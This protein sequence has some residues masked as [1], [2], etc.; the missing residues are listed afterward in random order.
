M[1]VQSTHKSYDAFYAKWERCR[2]VAEGSDAVHKAGKK[3]LP[4]LKDQND[5]DYAVY[6]QRAVFTNYTWRTIAVGVGMLFAKPAKIEV[7]ETI[8]PLLDDVDGEGTPMQLFVED[9][10]ENA[11]TVGRV[12]IMVDYPSAPPGATQADAKTLNLRPTMSIYRTES[13][14]NWRVASVNNRKVAVEVRLREFSEIVVDEFTTKEE[15]RLRVL[16]LIDTPTGK[17]YRQRLY[18]KKDTTVSSVEEY[19]QIGDDLFPLMH[20]ATMGYIPFYICST[21]DTTW[22]VDDPPLIDLVDL[23]LA[24][25]RNSAIYEQ[26]ILFSPPTML[27]TGYTPETEGEKI[28]VGSRTAITTR[29]DNA[30]GKFIEYTG[31]GLAPLEKAMDRKE[32]QMILLGSRALAPQQKAVE[33]ADTLAIKTKGEESVLSAAAQAISLSVTAALK[34]FVEWA[35][36]DPSGV[37]FEINRDFTQ[38]G[39]SA[40]MLSVKLAGWSQGA[41]GFSDQ[42][43]FAQMQEAEIVGK[44]VTLEE[45]QARI[46]S[47]PPQLAGQGGFGT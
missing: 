46:G 23:N 37:V 27:L 25:F 20:N 36:G 33:A 22:A 26:C 19:E 28:Y 29:N 44:D 41:P 21:D 7:P 10:A 16:D 24:H 6:N 1:P 39:L 38:L 11:L 45:E 40:Q 9:D 8:K 14:Y 18:R 42:S 13:I 43:F 47:R 2:T 5:A 32:Q 31:S 30:E 12:G 4:A 3:L 34:C 15:E 35:G 17:A